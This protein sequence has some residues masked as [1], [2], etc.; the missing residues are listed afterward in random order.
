MG[1]AL[2]MKLKLPI[3]HQ[4]KLRQNNGVQIFLKSYW[5]VNKKENWRWEDIHFVLENT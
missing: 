5:S 1:S 2:S 3:Q 4:W